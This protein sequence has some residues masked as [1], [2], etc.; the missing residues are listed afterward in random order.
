MSYFFG[1]KSEKKPKPVADN[2]PFGG[3]GDSE[4]SGRATESSF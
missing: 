2:T 4:R 1:K 3:G